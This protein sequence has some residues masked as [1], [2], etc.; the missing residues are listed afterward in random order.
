MLENAKIPLLGFAAFSGTGKTT[1]LSKV[2]P[3]LKSHGI[4]VGV[5][6]HA[7]HNFDI[8]HPGKDSHTLRHAGASQMLIASSKRWALM[9][10]TPEKNDAPD[11]NEMLSQLDQSKLDMILVEGFKGDSFPK[12]ELH[13][14]SLGKPLLHCDDKDII[15]IATDDA[16]ATDS[17]IPQLDINDEMKIIDFILGYLNI[18][19]QTEKPSIK[20]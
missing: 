17:P 9:T 4:R 1:L 6:K 5:L 20:A 7:H 12:I 15:A 11:L 14:Q 18:S 16:I 10:E 13:R 2:L 8:D 3:V 19:L